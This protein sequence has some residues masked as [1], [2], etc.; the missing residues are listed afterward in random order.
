MCTSIT[1]CA[2]CVPAWYSDPAWPAVLV[3][4]VSHESISSLKKRMKK[5]VAL[6]YDIVVVELSAYGGTSVASWREPRHKRC[7]LSA[8]AILTAPTSFFG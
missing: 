3:R 5:S 4:N 2:I 8:W 7:S 6:S 1:C